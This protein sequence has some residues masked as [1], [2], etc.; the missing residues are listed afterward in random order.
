M[1]QFYQ[2]LIPA[3]ER[4]RVEHLEPFDEYEEWHLKCNH[5]M[6]LCAYQK[7]EHHLLSHI[8]EQSGTRF[9]LTPFP[10]FHRSR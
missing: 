9:L 1:N 5:Y 4:G 8:K 7:T 3:E 2:E 6:M 10:P